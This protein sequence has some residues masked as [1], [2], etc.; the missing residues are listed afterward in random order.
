MLANFT[1]ALY[2]YTL[3]KSKSIC[4]LLC[5]FSSFSVQCVKF[6]GL[7]KISQLLADCFIYSFRDYKDKSKVTVSLRA[8]YSVKHS[9][10]FL[11]KGILG[12]SAV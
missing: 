3:F 8:N 11:Q 6:E 12:L 10:R 1:C 7:N 2:L 5:I 4:Y 9:F